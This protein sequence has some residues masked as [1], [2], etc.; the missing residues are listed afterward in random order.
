M[1]LDLYRVISWPRQ[2]VLNSRAYLSHSTSNNSTDHM[3][4]V[5]KLAITAGVAQSDPLP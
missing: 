4:A 5:H 1:H 2:N 3:T